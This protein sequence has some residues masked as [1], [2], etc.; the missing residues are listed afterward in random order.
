MRDVR[1]AMQD[2]GW[3]MRNARCKMREPGL[4]MCDVMPDGI[5]DARC[6]MRDAR[7]GMRDAGPRDAT[8][9]ASTD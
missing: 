2:A 8:S 4:G 6:E 9:A 7:C 1:C 5:Q 3:E